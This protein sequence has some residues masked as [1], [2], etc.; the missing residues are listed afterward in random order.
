VIKKYSR[1]VAYLTLFGVI[2]TMIWLLSYITLYSDDYQYAAFFREGWASFLAKTT[3]HYRYNNGR[4]LVHFLAE[5]FLLC[6]TKLYAVVFPFLLAAAFSLGTTLTVEKKNAFSPGAVA[7]AMAVL[8]ALPVEYLKET[9]CWVSGSFNY[10]FPFLLVMLY[11]TFAARSGLR[12]VL[13]AALFGFLAGATTEQSGLAALTGGCLLALSATVRRRERE[14]FPATR[15]LPVPF[16]LVGY[17]TVLLAPGTA[18]RMAASGESGFSVLLHPRLLLYRLETVTSYFAGGN[19]FQ[20]SARWLILALLALLGCLPLF[21]RRKRLWPLLAAFPTAVLYLLFLFLDWTLGAHLVLLSGLLLSS[22]CL[23]AESDFSADGVL[24]LSGLASLLV[25]VFTDLGAYRTVM[26]L[27]L[28][29]ITVLGRLSCAILENRSVFL[30]AAAVGGVLLICALLAFPTL[31]GY[32]ANAVLI[33]ENEEAIRT[34]RDTGTIILRTDFDDRYRHLLMFDGAY[35]FTQFRILYEIPTETAVYLEGVHYAHY[36]V[37]LE[38][39]ELPSHCIMTGGVLYLP[40]VD[41]FRAMGGECVWDFE[42]QNGYYLSCGGEPYY[43]SRTD[44]TIR[45]RETGAVAV[46]DVTAIGV[47]DKDYIDA[48]AASTFFGFTQEFDG[49]SLCLTTDR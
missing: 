1:P 15:W 17:L 13:L 27:L 41:L 23:L 49:T 37:L 40:L 32:R 8:L 12:N 44:G 43:L 14:R 31:R 28:F 7:V 4:A 36:P 46:T 6:G 19:G 45:H 18:S 30:R 34:G 48:L 3:D 26:P 10:C 39:A 24:L 21:F 42:G 20:V 2:G 47:L 16:V 5:L 35:F 9:L 11:F 38:G 25:M 33:R 22:V 29:L